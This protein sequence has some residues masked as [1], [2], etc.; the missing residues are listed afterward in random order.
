M[1]SLLFYVSRCGCEGKTLYIHVANQ[2]PTSICQTLA[3]QPLTAILTKAS[4][5]MIKAQHFSFTLNSISIFNIYG[6]HGYDSING[7]CETTSLWPNCSEARSTSE[8]YL[9]ECRKVEDTDWYE[10]LHGGQIIYLSK[11][12]MKQCM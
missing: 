11:S 4:P 3:N 1:L 8:E 2:P 6:N 9:E 10:R 5:N 7:R 12:F